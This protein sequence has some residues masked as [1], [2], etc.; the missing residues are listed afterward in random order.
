MAVVE[1]VMGAGLER[2]P[3]LFHGLSEAQAHGPADRP[4]PIS[5]RSSGQPV[6][7]A[8]CENH[9]DVRDFN[10]IEGGPVRNAG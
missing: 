8:N 7:S 5:L 9:H 3:W 6:Q 2:N 4:A 1:E 10:G